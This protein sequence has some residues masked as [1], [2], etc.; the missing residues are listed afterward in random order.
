[1][2]R[3]EV[4]QLS[5]EEVYRDIVRVPELY[6]TDA[7]G[8]KIRE[9]T[10]C[11]VRA[12]GR[13]AFVVLRGC[14]NQDKAWIAMD[15]LTRGPEK[16]N[17]E[18]NQTYDFDLEELGIIGQLRWAWNAAEMGYRISV[19]IAFFGFLLAVLGLILGAGSFP[20]SALFNLCCRFLSRAFSTQP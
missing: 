16:L 19:R 15:D 4:H 10:V 6:R 13:E 11:R 5:R 14:Q 7:R 20:W 1:M 12:N 2:P 3:L 18:R 9:G 8:R 17:L